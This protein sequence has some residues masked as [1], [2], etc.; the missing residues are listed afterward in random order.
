MALYLI[1]PMGIFCEQ[2]NTIGFLG[3]GLDKGV[4]DALSASDN[5]YETIV[6]HNRSS[7]VANVLCPL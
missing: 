3:E 1:N 7:G 6:V 2:R 4:K 5:Y